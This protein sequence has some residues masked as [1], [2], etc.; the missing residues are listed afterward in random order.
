MIR[1]WKTSLLL[2]ALSLTATSLFAGQEVASVLSW[3][4]R[5]RLL[6][7]T[8]YY[9]FIMGRYAKDAKGDPFEVRLQIIGG[10]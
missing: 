5:P 9:Q 10:I 2:C 4:A 7:R 8:G 3:Q 6:V 1:M